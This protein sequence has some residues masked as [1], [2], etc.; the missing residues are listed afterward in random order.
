MVDTALVAATRTFD[1]AQRKRFYDQVQRELYNDVPVVYLFAP[2]STPAIHR[3]FVGIKPAPAGIGYNS[4]HW[5]VPKAVQ[6]YRT[7]ISP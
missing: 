5:F 6:K 1:R 7:V 4:E 3:R 2:E